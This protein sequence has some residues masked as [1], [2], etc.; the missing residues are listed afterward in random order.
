LI[1]AISPD[2][3]LPSIVEAITASRDFWLAFAK[4]AEDV[5]R[6]KEETERARGAM[7]LSPGSYDPGQRVV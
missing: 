6:S 4:F 1:G 3:S 2:L 7:N 5:M